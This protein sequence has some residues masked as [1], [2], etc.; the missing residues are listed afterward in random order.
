VRIEQL[1]EI[2][3]NVTIY[4]REILYRNIY[5]YNYLNLT[6]SLFALPRLTKGSL[7]TIRAALVSIIPSHVPWIYHYINICIKYSFLILLMVFNIKQI[8]R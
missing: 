4:S 6:Y 1:S 7:W 5:G 2:R 8:F 3:Y